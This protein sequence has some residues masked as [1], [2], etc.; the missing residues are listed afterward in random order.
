MMI[1]QII[2]SVNAIQL[3]IWSIVIKFI[4]KTFSA[5]LCRI[6]LQLAYHANTNR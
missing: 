4:Y 1:F 5:C 6:H 2:F 3:L